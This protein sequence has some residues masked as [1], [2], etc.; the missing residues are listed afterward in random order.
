MTV[1]AAVSPRQ[2]TREPTSGIFRCIPR[3]QPLS[4]RILGIDWTDHLPLQIAD[5]VTL[6]CASLDEA[7][8]FASAHYAIIF[9]SDP[10][11][12][13]FFVEPST[14]AKAR[15]LAES[16]RFLFREGDRAIGLLIGHPTDWSTYYW[17]SVAFLSEHQGRGLLAAALE[18]TDAVMGAAGVVRV[19]GDVAPN[20]Y[21]QLRLLLRLGYSVTGS[22]NS[23]RWGAMLRLTKHLTPEAEQIFTTQFCREAPRRPAPHAHPSGNGG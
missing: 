1:R 16:D 2:C 5:G 8:E 9:G 12:Q 13:R 22:V 23:E 19:E 7:Q 15:F 4:T 14:P 21:R 6:T 18:H 11:D 10:Q 20:N 17:R 3:D